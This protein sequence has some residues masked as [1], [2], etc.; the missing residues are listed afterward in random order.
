MMLR[1]GTAGV[2]R[3]SPKPDTISGIRRLGEL[4][5][6]HLEM[7]WVRRVQV[8]R[9]AG[10]GIRRAAEKAGITLTAHGPYYINL[11]SPERAKL[12]ASIKRILD[13]ARQAHHCG[14]TSITFHAAFMMKCEPDAVYETVKEHLRGILSTLAR[15]KITVDVR[16][17]LSGK[18]S[19]WGS[20][21]EVIRISRELEGVK[22]V[23]DFSHLHAREGGAYNTY[24]EFAE[25]L[26]TIKSGLGQEAL[27]DMHI[28][29]SGI[30]YGPRGEREHLN[31]E[32]SDFNY[33]Q[34]IKAFI[35]Y[36][37]EG[38][39]VCESPN[40]EVD[41]LMLQ[42]TYLEELKAR[43]GGNAPVGFSGS[44]PTTSP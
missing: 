19:Q 25:V 8:N 1:F 38:W 35:D 10:E 27:K 6:H 21:E 32:E 36:G 11:N 41:A 22:P 18:P 14:A 43:G 42:Q 40:L 30:K 17:E 2:P 13:T 23:V 9:K 37:V 28:H 24:G 26:E 39:C 4:G 5:L 20:L 44:P 34:L 16:P 15:E 29:V 3:S 31:L 7:E 12:E 33:R